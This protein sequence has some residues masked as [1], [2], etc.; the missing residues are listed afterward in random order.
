MRVRIETIRNMKDSD[1]DEWIGCLNAIDIQVDGKALR[2]KGEF[3]I[4]EKDRGLD[5]TTTYQIVE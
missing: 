2:D 4:K 5:V 1:Y 3:V